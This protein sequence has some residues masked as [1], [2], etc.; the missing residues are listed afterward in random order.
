MINGSQLRLLRL[1]SGLS[2]SQLA[3]KLGNGG[4][5]A[6]VIGAIENDKRKI[7]F[8]FLSDWCKACG[9]RIET[10]ENEHGFSINIIKEGC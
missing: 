3:E 2:Q 4:Y 5:H 9:Y 7:G 8:S 10:V 6:K 1:S